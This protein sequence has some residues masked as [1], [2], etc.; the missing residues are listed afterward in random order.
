[1]ID[2]GQN[3]TFR[4]YFESLFQ[5]KR[6]HLKDKFNSTEWIY[7]DMLDFMKLHQESSLEMKNKN[8]TLKIKFETKRLIFG[9]FS[10]AKIISYNRISKRSEILK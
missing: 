7:I 6:V 1:M 3:D 8:Y 9:G 2:F 5:K 10:I 4:S